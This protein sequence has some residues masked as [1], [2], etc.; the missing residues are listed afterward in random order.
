LK[1]EAASWPA[2]RVLLDVSIHRSLEI[3]SLFFECGANAD[4]QDGMDCAATDR[5]SSS[6]EDAHVRLEIIVAKNKNPGEAG[7]FSFS[8][9]KY[10]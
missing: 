10:F 7:V 1:R 9:V 6:C 2:K 5:C 8:S 3:I 4:G